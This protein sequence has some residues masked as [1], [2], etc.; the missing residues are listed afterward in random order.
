MGEVT[1]RHI[2]P[3]EWERL[4]GTYEQQG[5]TLPRAEQN[6]AIVAEVDGKI[7]G[8]W[9]INL[10]IHAGPLWVDPEWRGKGVPDQMGVALDEL[11][12]NAGGKGYLMFPSNKGSEQVAVRMGLKPAAWKIYV[13]EF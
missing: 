11:V 4:R 12:K 8:M 5:D 1:V 10:L 9:G 13:K 7:V 6:T 3:E 2:P